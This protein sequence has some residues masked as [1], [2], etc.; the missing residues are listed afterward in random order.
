MTGKEKCK[1]LRQI[2]QE[3]AETNGIVYIT[4]DCTYEGDDCKGT[5]PKCD[6]EI[7]YLDAELN[8]K[9]ADGELITLAGLSLDTFQVGVASTEKTSK[10]FGEDDIPAAGGLVVEKGN[11]PVGGC[12]D[13]TIEELDLSVRS[14]NCLKRANINTVA[15]LIEKTEED[16]MK[17]RNMGRKSLEEIRKKLEMM[18]LS[19]KASDLDE[20]EEIVEG[21]LTVV[22]GLSDGFESDRNV[23]EMTIFDLDLSVRSF[24]CLKRAGVSTVGDLLEMTES[25]VS[26][27][28]NM[29]KKSTEEVV[30]K[31]ATMG[32]KLKDEPMDDIP[33]M[34]MV[35]PNDDDETW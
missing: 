32:L 11:M 15:E 18:G 1:L 17:V 26:K 29:S 10:G 23:R 30:N 20:D 24:N 22:G 13:L 9:I 25:E 34:G 27:L 7:T 2:R 12:L 8:R 19:Y 21:D 35:L 3:I 6:E 14:Y 4:T 28:R 5:C 16:M 31:L 33:L